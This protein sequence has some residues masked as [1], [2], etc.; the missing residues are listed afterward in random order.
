V[1]K[2]GHAHL[3]PAAQRGTRMPAGHPEGL[4]EAFANIYANAMRVIGARLTGEAPDPLDLDFPTVRDGASG[5]HFIQAALQS[6]R[7]GG[8]VDASYDA[9]GA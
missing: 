7:E 3:I 4:L 8:W 2:P 1:Y 6:G 5:V 9:P